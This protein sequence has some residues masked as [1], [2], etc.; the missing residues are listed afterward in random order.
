MI[1]TPTILTSLQLITLYM[2]VVIAQVFHGHYFRKVE[3]VTTVPTL[4]SR[5]NHFYENLN[6]NDGKLIQ[7]YFVT[8]YIHSFVFTL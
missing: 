1:Y 8:K 4:V 3:G 7:D 6:T 2:N 5:V